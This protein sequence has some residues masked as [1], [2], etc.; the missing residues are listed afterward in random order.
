MQNFKMITKPKSLTFFLVIIIA[1]LI[2]YA[3][4]LEILRPAETAY[5]MY[6]RTILMCVSIFLFL[7]IPLDQRKSIVKVISL[8]LVALAFLFI[9]SSIIRSINIYRWDP[10]PS[11]FYTFKLFRLITI[12]SLFYV[13]LFFLFGSIY[14]V[15]NKTI[16]LNALFSIKF[17]MILFLGF[18][19]IQ[20]L[21]GNLSQ[22]HTNLIETIQALP[23]TQEERLEFRL[24]GQSFNGWI[25]PYT[26]FIKQQTPTDSVILIPPQSSVWPME[27]N[28]EYLR[29]FLYPRQLKHLDIDKRIPNE[30]NFVL[31][32]QGECMYGECGWPKQA[33]PAHNIERITLIDPKTRE[34][35]TLEDVDYIP[36]RHISHWGIIKLKD[37]DAT[38]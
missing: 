17:V 15:R 14:I 8:S 32:A 24:R 16:A 30:I 38:N 25:V 5:L 20:Q 3:V 4:Y 11:F 29:W 33:I 21:Q 13:H 36:D 7:L 34:V 37:I 35:T 26:R 22:S 19:L 12:S 1:M 31:I 27:G 9:S 18:Y 6:Y 23:T 28:A 10:L 2:I